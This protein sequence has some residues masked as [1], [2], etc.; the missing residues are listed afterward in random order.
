MSLFCKPRFAANCLI[1]ASSAGPLG[2]G[3]G[4][5]SVG[6]GVAV[7]G[8]LFS[9]ASSVDAAF[10]TQA[11]IHRMNNVKAI[12]TLLILAPSDWIDAPLVNYVP[13]NCIIDTCDIA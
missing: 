3:S 7:G 9:E 13:N 11:V 4:F 10:G 5:V 2:I 8:S 6:T 12:K 1:T